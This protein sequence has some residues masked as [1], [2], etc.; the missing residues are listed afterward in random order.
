MSGA[1]CVFVVPSRR[2]VVAFEGKVDKVDEQGQ[3]RGGQGQG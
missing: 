1:E 2:R 3:A